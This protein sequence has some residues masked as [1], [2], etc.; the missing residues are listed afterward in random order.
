MGCLCL[1]QDKCRCKRRQEA[2]APASQAAAAASYYA[3]CTHEASVPAAAVSTASPPE[4]YGERGAYSLLEFSLC[5]LRGAM[6]D[7]SPLLM[8][9]V[10]GFGCVYRDAANRCPVSATNRHR[11][12]GP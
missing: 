1:F 4:L 12:A 2:L 8:V 3:A 10:G 11:G 7:F 5:E 6:A 9:G